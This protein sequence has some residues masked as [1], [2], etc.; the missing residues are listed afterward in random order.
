[1]EAKLNA[2]MRNVHALQN[3]RAYCPAASRGINVWL[4][5]VN[6]RPLPAVEM[7]RPAD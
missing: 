4:E 5:F 1:M 7:F 3:S 2:S 6:K